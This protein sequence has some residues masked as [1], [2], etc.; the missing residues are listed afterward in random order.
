MNRTVINR[1]VVDLANKIYDTV[2]EYR[3]GDYSTDDI[4]KLYDTLHN[5]EL[6]LDKLVVV[7]RNRVP[8]NDFYV[9]PTAVPTI[10]KGTRKH[11][12]HTGPSPLDNP[13]ETDRMRRFNR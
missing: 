8:N 2:E 5:I 11:P 12:K 6:L 3:T 13:H 7:N 1:K 4:V 10:I 9:G